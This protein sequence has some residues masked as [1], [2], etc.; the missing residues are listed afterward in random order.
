MM[1]GGERSC[2]V[3]SRVGVQGGAWRLGGL[4]SETGRVEGGGED[5]VVSS[6]TGVVVGGAPATGGIQLMERGWE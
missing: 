5:G 6:T 2:C 1:V 4:S 3:Q